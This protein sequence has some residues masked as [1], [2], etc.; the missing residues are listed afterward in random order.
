MCGRNKSNSVMAL[1]WCQLAISHR[2]EMGIPEVLHLQRCLLSR[3]LATTSQPRQLRMQPRGNLRLLDHLRVIA[4]L[5]YSRRGWLI[6]T[7]QEGTG[8]AWEPPL[9]LMTYEKQNS[10]WGASVE[11]SELSSCECSSLKWVLMNMCSSWKVGWMFPYQTE[12]WNFHRG[13]LKTLFS[14]GRNTES[15]LPSVLGV[16]WTFFSD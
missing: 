11:S 3:S 16:V 15:Q 8:G 12:S 2:S 7:W 1:S 6:K 14:H 10:L 4:K 5:R 13:S 9:L